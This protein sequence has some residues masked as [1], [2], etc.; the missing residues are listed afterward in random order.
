MTM[1]KIII[2]IILNLI[3]FNF[4]SSQNKVISGQVKDANNLPC[5]YVLVS[6]LKQD[7]NI[8]LLS[9]HTDSLG[10]YRLNITDKLD[11]YGIVISSWGIQLHKEIIPYFEET[12]KKKDII[13]NNSGE[14]KLNEIVVKGEQSVFILDNDR[15]VYKPDIALLTS[16][17][18]FDV[19]K[20]MPLIKI[21]D[22]NISLLSKT[23]TKVYLN[24]QP[25]RIPLD[26][27]IQYLKTMPSD[28][29]KNI[30]IIS[31]PGSRYEAS[32]TGGIIN[33]NLHKNIDDGLQGQI[34]LRDEQARM[35]GQSANT[36]FMYRRKKLGVEWGVS[37]YNNPNKSKDKTNLELKTGE[38]QQINSQNTFKTKGLNTNLNFEYAISDCHLINLFSTV[39]FYKPERDQSSYTRYSNVNHPTSIDSTIHT[40][41]KSK[42][43]RINNYFLNTSYN[44]KIDDNGQNLSA[45]IDYMNYSNKQYNFTNSYLVNDDLEHINKLNDYTVS[46]PQKITTYSGKIDYTLPLNPN[47]SLISGIF[48]THNK[49]NNS[50]LWKDL[51]KEEYILNKK[52][53]NQFKYLEKISAY[54]ITLNTNLSEKIKSSVGLRVEYTDIRAKL[55]DSENKTFKNNYWR[56]FPSLSLLYKTSNS[57]SIN[58]SLSGKM[59]RPGFWQLN[60]ARYYINENLYSTNNPNLESVQVLVQELSV[61]LNGKYSLI[62]GYNYKKNDIGRF[63]VPDQNETSINYFGLFNYGSYSSWYANFSASFNFFD[64]FWKS[65]I[66]TGVQFESYRLKDVHII[67]YYKNEQSWS[68]TLNISNTFRF[69][70]KQSLWGYLNFRYSSPNIYLAEKNRTYPIFNFEIKKIWRSF[71]ISLAVNDIFNSDKSI[72]QLTTNQT[73]SAYTK[74]DYEFYPDSRSFQIRLSYH[75]GNSK[76]KRNKSN[77][78]ANDENRN[79]VN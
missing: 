55:I 47:I 7:S 67:Q 32:L 63:L 58:Y 77:K 74:N 71:T 24:N 49:T 3:T 23:G 14:I 13:I 53:S 72:S 22:Q 57:F 38:I 10:L 36:N 15:L 4:I 2:Y 35:N 44:F 65:N 5:E 6:L 64:G 61:L 21:D 50:Y 66:F 78:I 48:Y 20:Q 8:V 56:F 11:N 39:R 34:M 30:E 73:L 37:I 75:F 70:Q 33:I 1:R 52:R 54:Y 27:L 45:S 62:I 28:N 40:T 29:I 79:R 76:T 18:T 51:Y 19:L 12:S 25:L 26:M 60:P 17:T 41:E 59:N 9:T 43:N 68:G 16:N 69:S 46:A 31:N 42:G